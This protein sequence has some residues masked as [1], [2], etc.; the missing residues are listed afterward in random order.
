LETDCQVHNRTRSHIL[1]I[2]ENFGG[3]AK[4]V[5]PSGFLGM[6]PIESK[7]VQGGEPPHFVERDGLGGL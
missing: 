1:A 7:P 5:W 2:H 6:R 4:V 3:F